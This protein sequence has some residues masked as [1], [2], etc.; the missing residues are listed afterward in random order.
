MTNEQTALLLR[1]YQYRVR[2]ILAIA[3]RDDAEAAV[4]EITVSLGG[5]ITG[6]HGVGHTQRRHL[7][8]RLAPR[9]ID[10]M[11]ALKQAFDPRGILNPYKIFP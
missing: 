7:S 5:S 3:R 8:L 11:K 4:M 2:T 6:E 1:G 9:A 10:L